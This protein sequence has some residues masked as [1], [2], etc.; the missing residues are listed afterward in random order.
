MRRNLRLGEQI[1][2]GEELRDRAAEPADDR[3]L[4]DGD[5]HRHAFDRGRERLGIERLHR[6]HVQHGGID[7]GSGQLVRGREAN[8][9][10]DAGRDQKSIVAVAHRDRSADS[11]LAGL[12]R[13]DRV[14]P[15]RDAD[16]DRP[17][18]IERR[19]HGP[20]HLIRIGRREDRHVRQSH[21][22]SQ[23]PRSPDAS[24]RAAHRPR[25]R[26]WR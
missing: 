9:Q 25:R 5:D 22:G 3:V 24:G 13:H 11:E 2:F 4:L 23:C 7:A 8:L 16:V 26:R 19:A 20:G 6:R 10:A 18:V 21:A 17:R 1:R 12:G 15:L 14:V